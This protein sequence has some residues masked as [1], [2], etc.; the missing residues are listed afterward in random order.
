[1][2]CGGCGCLPASGKSR[3]ACPSLATTMASS[4]SAESS[5]WWGAYRTSSS[6]S[7][8]PPGVIHP[9]R[10]HCKR[11]MLSRSDV[12]VCCGLANRRGGSS[13]ARPR[14]STTLRPATGATAPHSSTPRPAP[15]QAAPRWWQ[16]AT[17]SGPWQP[18]GAASRARAKRRLRALGL[19]RRS[20]GRRSRCRPA[21]RRQAGAPAPP[22]AASALPSTSS[23]SRCGPPPLAQATLAAGLRCS[24]RCPAAPALQGFI[25]LDTATGQRPP[26]AKCP[27]PA[28]FLARR[29]PFC[30]S[31]AGRP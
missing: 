25:G 22:P 15:T 8:H 7:L 31:C 14:S 12:L 26:S 20:G 19:G 11:V 21:R 2:S 29:C 1:M 30:A 13:P 16:W 3:A 23:P 18:A 27:C 5:G 24:R 28:A 9:S 4:R 17:G 10:R 6:L